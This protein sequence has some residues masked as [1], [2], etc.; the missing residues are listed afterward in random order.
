MAA[1]VVYILLR[2]VVWFAIRLVG[3]N[4]KIEGDVQVVYKL[5]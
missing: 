4:F 3:Q 5:F 2:R 1:A